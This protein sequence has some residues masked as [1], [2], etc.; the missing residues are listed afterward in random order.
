MKVVIVNASL[1]AGAQGGLLTPGLT[2]G[3]LLAVILGGV[4]SLLWP[5]IPLGAFAIVGAAAFLATSM[6]MPITAIVL[7]A[8]FTRI[9]HDLL[10]PV[11]A[12]VAG[13]IGIS[14]LCRHF[15]G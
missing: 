10:F 4:W 3:A 6:N 11:L 14:R 12:A 15:S 7:I 1:R 9:D 5:G 13:S 2:L 8:E